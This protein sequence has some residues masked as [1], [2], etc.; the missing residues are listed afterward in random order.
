MK[1][2]SQNLGLPPFALITETMIPM[3][4]RILYVMDESGLIEPRLYGSAL[5]SALHQW[6]Q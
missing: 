3:V 5:R 4:A 2:L 1:E 6:L